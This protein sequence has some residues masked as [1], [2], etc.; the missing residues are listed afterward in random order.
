MSLRLPALMLFF[1]A[2][3]TPCLRRTAGPVGA[4]RGCAFAA[5]IFPVRGLRRGYGYVSRTGA[6]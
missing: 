5:R 6:A 2:L 3:A 4:R 1:R